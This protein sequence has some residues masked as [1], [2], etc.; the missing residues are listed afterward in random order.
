MPKI[1]SAEARDILRNVLNVNPDTRY[2]IPQIRSSRWYN[3]Y[4]SKNEQ[5]GIIVGKDQINPDESIVRKM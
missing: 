2:K 5:K 3:I 4:K 1:L